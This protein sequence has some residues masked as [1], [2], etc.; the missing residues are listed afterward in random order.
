M[1]ILIGFLVAGL[2]FMMAWKTTSF[3]EFTGR[4]DW[5]EEK[6]GPGGS[7]TFLKLLGIGTILLG[8]MIVTN[9]HVNVLQG[10]AGL[11]TPSR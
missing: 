10:F 3:L 8:F 5:A 2:G 6:L 1:H 9:L 11:F 7:T 4:I